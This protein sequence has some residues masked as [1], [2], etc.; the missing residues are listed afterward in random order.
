MIFTPAQTAVIFKAITDI[1]AGN[2]GWSF[3]G[4]ADWLHTALQA[5]GYTVIASRDFHGA[6]A[7][8]G[9]TRRAQQALNGAPYAV[10][11]Y[12]T[13]KDA[14]YNTAKDASPAPDY[15]AAILARQESATMDF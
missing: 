1:E 3:I 9:Y 12:N 4:S 14:Y 15:E 7:F 8:K 11:N 5:A 6:P 13:V 2:N 10:S